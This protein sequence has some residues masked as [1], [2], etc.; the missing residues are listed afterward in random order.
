MARATCI[1]FHFNH[2]FDVLG[3]M[4]NAPGIISLGWGCARKNSCQNNRKRKQ[5]CGFHFYAPM[6]EDAGFRAEGS[7]LV[8]EDG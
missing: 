5:N 1:V 7:K 6:T 2:S 8:K 4:R 3:A